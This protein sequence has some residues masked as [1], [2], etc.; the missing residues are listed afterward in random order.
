MRCR[1][2][3]KPRRAPPTWSK[4][5]RWR[6]RRG[7]GSF[8]GAAPPNC[9][10]GCVR[11][12]SIIFA[13]WNGITAARPSGRR[14]ARSRWPTLLAPTTL[15]THLSGTRRRRAAI[16]SIKSNPSNSR[17]PWI[18]CRTTT[19]KSSSGTIATIAHSPKSANASTARPAP[20]GSSGPVR[21]V[22][23]KSASRFSMNPER[24]DDLFE[25]SLAEYDAALAEGLPRPASS[26]EVDDALDSAKKCLDLLEAVWPRGATCDLAARP[27]HTE[28]QFAQAT[29]H[30]D[31]TLFDLPRQLG[32]FEIIRELGR[33]GGGIVFLARDPRLNR[34]VALKVPRADFLFT[35][36]L[37][38]R[39]LR[40]S[41]TAA[42]LNHPH[43]VPIY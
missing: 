1:A 25:S 34:H 6:R 37:R 21:C 35:P 2:I 43:I 19:G 15:P 9:S 26:G 33:G 14:P 18:N 40:E 27:H 38:R 41:E 24:N 22:N 5:P 29:L 7:S 12:C 13:T 31:D 36:E 28:I 30:G 17:G 4:R 32:R 11:Y 42:Q 3:C 23:C 39:F 20:R 16:C 8:A 10:S